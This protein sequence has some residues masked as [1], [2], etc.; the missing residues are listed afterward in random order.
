MN[1][2]LLKQKPA[3]EGFLH[4]YEWKDE[5]GTKYPAHA[6]KGKVTLYILEGCLTFNFG[7]KVV[8]LKEGDRFNVPI[9]EGH[10]AKVGKNGCLYLVGE[11]IEGDS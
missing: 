5:P 2:D 8:T 9:G 7:E 1:T 10:T 11:L 6:H 3:E 4:I